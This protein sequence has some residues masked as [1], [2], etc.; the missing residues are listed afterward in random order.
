MAKIKVLNTNKFDVGISLINPPR[1]Q[2]IRA[3]SFTMLDSEDIYY[4]DSICT[5]FKRGYLTIQS[6]EVKEELGYIENNEGIKTEKE[7]EEILKG[8]FLKMKSSLGKITEPH[9]KDLVYLVTTKIYDDL[10]G[11]KLKF[12]SQFCNREVSPI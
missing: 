7:I 10:N 12:I 3:G 8:N 2:N 9:I 1:E 11:S 6:E 5:L 4:L